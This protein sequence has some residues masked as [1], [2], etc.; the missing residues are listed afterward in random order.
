[1]KS[2]AIIAPAFLA[3][4]IVLS[5]SS[6]DLNIKPP[7]KKPPKIIHHASPNLHVDTDWIEQAGCALNEHNWGT[8]LPDS[9]LKKLGCDEIWVL[10]LFGGLD[11][12]VIMCNSNEVTSP[13]AHF[14]HAGC[15]LSEHYEAYIMFRDG[16]Y[17]FVEGIREFRSLFAPI[18]SA[19]E[20]LSYA[21]AATDYY[22]TYEIEIDPEYTYFVDEIEE[23]YAKDVQDGYLL[24]L[25]I[26]LGEC[27]GSG[28]TDAVDIVVRRDGTITYGKHQA[29]S[30]YERCID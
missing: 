12:P 17:Q 16:E 13:G 25:F 28:S 3:L 22:A 7:A 18:E 23:T 4:T 8:C 9:P 5:C 20:A 29:I 15:Y 30:E 19:D 27:C 10:D 2:V 26:D 6:F 1:M 21:L 14:V 11:Y 24:H